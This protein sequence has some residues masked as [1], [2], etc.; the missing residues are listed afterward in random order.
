MTEGAWSGRPKKDPSTSS[1]DTCYYCKKAGHNKKKY[2]KYKEILK[3]KDDNDTDGDSISEKSEQ[4]DIV[5]EAD[6]NPCDVLT[7]QEEKVLL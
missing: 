6:D 3:K 5:E 2:L 7:Y 1:S 4:T